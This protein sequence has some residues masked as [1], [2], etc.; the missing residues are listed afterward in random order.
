[1]IVINGLITEVI[2][3]EGMLLTNDDINYTDHLYLG[4]NDSPFNWHEVPIEEGE[5]DG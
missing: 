3:D 1:M 4:K 2:P 5:Q